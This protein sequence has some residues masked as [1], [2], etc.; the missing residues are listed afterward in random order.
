MSDRDSSRHHRS[1]LQGIAHRAMLDRGLE[2]DF[3]PAAATEL[4]E[5]PVPSPNGVRDLTSLLWCS[6]DNDDSR[7]LDQL[8]AGE[9]VAGDGARIYV[10][11][12]DVDVLVGKGTAIDAHAQR[13]TTSVYTA[14]QIFPML[15][16]E[17][18]TDRTSLNVDSDRLAIVVEMVVDG[19]GAVVKSDVYRGR[20]RNRAQL[21]Y[22]S[23]G[24]WLENER[25]AP[26]ALEA[27]PDLAASLRLQDKVAQKMKDRRHERGALSLDTINRRPCS[28][29]RC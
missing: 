12:A 25:P 11:I 1:I 7:D 24:A 9:P 4:A 29:E 8:T 26:A 5:L 18:S 14:A 17:L 27:V 3:P 13:N 21:A 28:R 2:P 19:I 16:E 23:V 20:V 6:I 15:P 10:A 22:P